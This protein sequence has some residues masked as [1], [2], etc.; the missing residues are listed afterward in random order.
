MLKCVG[1]LEVFEDE[2]EFV[3]S[4]SVCDEIGIELAEVIVIIVV[5]GVSPS[6]AGRFE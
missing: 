4:G 5:I 3:A 2:S 6:V 1:V